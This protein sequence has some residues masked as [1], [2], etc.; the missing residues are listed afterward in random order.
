MIDTKMDDT[1]L[2]AQLLSERFSPGLAPQLDGHSI[3]RI[4]DLE[5][6]QAM[7]S[8]KLIEFLCASHRLY[9]HK[10]I[11]EIGLLFSLAREQGI[12]HIGR[13]KALFDH[14]IADLHQ[15]FCLEEDGLFS[16]ALELED[17]KAAPEQGEIGL[18]QNLADHHDAPE[19][20]LGAVVHLLEQ[21]LLQ[22]GDNSILR[23]LKWKI[24]RLITDLV[25]HARIEDE[26][27]IPRIAELESSR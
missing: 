12:P 25:W 27:L 2:T 18:W 11:P 9:E 3:P 21:S 13:V 22:H 16:Y 20:H 15:H 24:E 10:L 4:V 6:F 8:S 17:K 1:V 19:E 7:S 23:R 26:V 5:Y 14:L